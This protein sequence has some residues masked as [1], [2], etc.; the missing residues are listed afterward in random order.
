MQLQCA[1]SLF[2]LA[3]RSRFYLAAD[4]KGGKVSSDD[5]RRSRSDFYGDF[6]PSAYRVKEMH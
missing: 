6:L 3:K 4:L 1:S 2:T 5:L